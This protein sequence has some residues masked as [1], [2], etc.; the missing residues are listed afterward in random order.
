[1]DDTTQNANLNPAIS[2]SG[3]GS[4]TKE[5]GS[6]PM[7]VG[8]RTFNNV[9]E[10]SKAYEALEK[11]YTRKSQAL[12]D[13]E[14]R[15]QELEV[16]VNNV[17]AS[18]S[19]PPTEA[20][21]DVSKAVHLLKSRGVATMDEIDTLLALRDFSAAKNNQAKYDDLKLSKDEERLILERYKMGI[22]MEDT[23][24]ALKSDS[25]IKH[26]TEE[27]DAFTPP[28]VTTPGSRRTELDLGGKK[29]K[30]SELKLDS[31]GQMTAPIKDAIDTVF[32]ALNSSTGG[33]SVVIY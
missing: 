23:F 10:I 20:D 9:E 5:S 12:A 16:A 3:S 6:S 8:G 26:A 13:A 28:Q 15:R 7:Q 33:D 11:D 1:M 4:D 2:D 31:D 32:D 17:T 27:R 14:R 18:S 21:D 29:I 25:I 19:N 24:K 22:P 30:P